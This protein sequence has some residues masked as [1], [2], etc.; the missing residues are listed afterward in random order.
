MLIYMI[1]YPSYIDQTLTK[2]QG[3]RISKKNSVPTP[4]LKE[5]G[6]ALERLGI[7]HELQKDR[8]YPKKPYE[9]EGRIL[10][11]D[12]RHKQGLLKKISKEV[13]RIRTA[14]PS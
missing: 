5:I 11:Q 8:C 12:L 10:I 7:D 1:I 3:R 6:A 4:K 2:K 14:A 13:K 9:K